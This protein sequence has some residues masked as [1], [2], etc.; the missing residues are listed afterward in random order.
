MT[1]KALRNL[2]IDL[3]HG[4]LADMTPECK[5]Q[6]KGHDQKGRFKD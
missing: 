6:V 4:S 1:N 5:Y 2:H 3:G